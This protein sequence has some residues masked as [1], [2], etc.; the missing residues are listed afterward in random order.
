MSAQASQCSQQT[1]SDTAPMHRSESINE[2]L[3][4]N[5]D[6]ASEAVGTTEEGKRLQKSK[7]H[8][9][10]KSH[11]KNWGPYVSGGWP[12]QGGREGA[13]TTPKIA[14]GEP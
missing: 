9:G 1:D 8:L 7:G 10:F 12:H 13:V 4:P 3:D 14:R 2:I 11:W 5:A 6:K